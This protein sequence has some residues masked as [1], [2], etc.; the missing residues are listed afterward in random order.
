VGLKGRDKLTARDHELI[1]HYRRLAARF[2][3]M[4]DTTKGWL[5]NK[6]WVVAT[7]MEMGIAPRKRAVR[8]LDRIRKNDVGKYG[9]Y[10]SA[11]ERRAMMTIS[12]G[13]LAVSEANYGR[14]DEALWYMDRIVATFGRRLPGS[15]SEMM[16]DYGCFVQAWTMYGI[17]VPLVQH[18]FGVQ[19]DAAR[20]TV[21][22]EPHLPNG[23]EEIGIEDLP[24]GS[25]VISFAGSRTDKGIEYRLTAK[26]D[27]WRFVLR[28]PAQG[29]QYYVNGKLV[30]TASAGVQLTGRENRILV[31]PP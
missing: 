27:G 4:A 5:T 2:A 16:P 15:I 17:V 19:P 1:E 31:V 14:T 28:A 10:L 12:T 13:V 22:L 21:L 3:E 9:P 30:Q 8:V 29:V 25:N 11:V 23:W 6:N 18:V 7:P 24:V 26:E 20:K